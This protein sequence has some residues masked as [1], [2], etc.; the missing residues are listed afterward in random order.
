MI[1]FTVNVFSIDDKGTMRAQRRITVFSLLIPQRST[2]YQT[3]E[4]TLY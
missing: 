2:M 3:T 1:S 4:Q